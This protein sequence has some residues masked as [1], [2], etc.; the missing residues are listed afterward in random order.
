M[1][2]REPINEI[3]INVKARKGT[4]DTLN[5]LFSDPQVQELLLK[6]S[7]ELEQKGKS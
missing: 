6:K 5:K 4:D 2:K 3:Q 1:K 7:K